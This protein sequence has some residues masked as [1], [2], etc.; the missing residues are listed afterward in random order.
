MIPSTIMAP[1]RSLYLLLACIT[2]GPSAPMQQTET[3]TTSADSTGPQPD[4]T[5]TTVTPTTSS[6]TT[7]SSSD[8]TFDPTTTTTTTTSI[9]TTTPDELTFIVPS[10]FSCLRS[11]S[12]PRCT[13]CDFFAQDCPDGEKCT[14]WANDGGTSWNANRCVPV[15]PDP[16][17]VG[18]PCT[19][20]DSPVSGFDTCELASMCWD[21]DPDTLAGTCIGFCDGSWEAPTCPDGF[22]CVANNTLALCF[23][24]CDPLAQ[25]CPPDE[26]CLESTP[27]SFTCILDVSGDQGQALD[28]CAQ[29]NACDVGLTCMPAAAA[30]ECAMAMT[31]CCLPFCD[32]SLPPNCPGAQQTCV[33]WFAE[34]TAPPDLMNL[35]VCSLAP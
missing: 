29:L 24:E 26:L 12:S 9:S 18:E 35:G 21:V 31:D 10:D 32:L 2:C 1:S 15:V 7:S 14:F 27:G 3:T 30:S 20:V 11:A 4:P 23:A 13:E 25:D 28:P 22:A 16:D 33:P 6:S 34:G 5:T 19:V 17:L 8:T